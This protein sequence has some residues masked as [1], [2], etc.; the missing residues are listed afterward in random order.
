MSNLILEQDLAKGL[1]QSQA[2]CLC[3]WRYRHI[4]Q[5]KEARSLQLRWR[6]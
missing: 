4:D 6:I 2:L 3:G 1:V 5:G